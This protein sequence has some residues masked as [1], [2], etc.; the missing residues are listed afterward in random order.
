MNITL[1]ELLA[2]VKDSV[3]AGVQANVRLTEPDR[4]RINQADAKRYIS[5][6]GFRPSMI[7]KWTDAGLITKR[8][9]GKAQN[10]SAW[11]SL[12]EIKQ[13]LVSVRIKRIT[14]EQE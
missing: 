14:N 4:D 9:K 8:K 7:A 5:R 2:L 1:S 10:S 13:L 11:Y 3:D 6:L 12:N